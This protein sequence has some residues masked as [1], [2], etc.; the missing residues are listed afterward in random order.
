MPDIFRLTKVEA[1]I[2][3]TRMIRSKNI[4]LQSYSF[5]VLCK[6]D[7]SFFDRYDPFSRFN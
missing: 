1:A 4:T 3:K 7:N 5:L 2:T 6:N